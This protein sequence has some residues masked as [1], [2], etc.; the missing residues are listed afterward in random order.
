MLFETLLSVVPKHITFNSKE[1]TVSYTRWTNYMYVAYP[2]VKFLQDINSKWKH[3][4]I[5]Y[6]VGKI[7]LAYALLILN[8]IQTFCIWYQLKVIGDFNSGVY[9]IRQK[10]VVDIQCVYFISIV[11]HY[12]FTNYAV[13][14][15]ITITTTRQ[16]L[17][18]YSIWNYECSPW[19]GV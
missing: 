7:I 10:R 6:S 1:T 11:R 15:V 9:W 18:N 8:R 12:S 2:T 3:Y 16:Y 4:D 14:I 5:K 13:L 19:Y 17:F